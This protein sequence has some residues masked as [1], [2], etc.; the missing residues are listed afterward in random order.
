M[1][2]ITLCIGTTEGHQKCIKRYQCWRHLKYRA[3]GDPN[4]STMYAPN[5]HEECPYFWQVED[6][7][8]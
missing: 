7:P 8:C 1:N 6:P 2:D 5:E 3:N 4:A